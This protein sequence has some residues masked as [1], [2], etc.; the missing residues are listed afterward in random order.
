MKKIL[1]VDDSE[2]NLKILRMILTK[3]GY[4]VVTIKSPE[5]VLDELE[6]GFD[7]IILDINM[8]VKNGYDLCTEIILD[9]RYKHIPVIFNS[10]LSNSEDIVKGFR[11][12]AVDYITKPFKADEVKV[13]VNTHL[14]I[15]DL[16]NEL[17]QTNKLLEQK[18][19]EQVQK[20]S[21]TQMETIFSLARLAQ[22]RD[23]DTG[24]H[25]ERV[26]TYCKLLAEKLQA[27]S[28]YSS[29]IDN[30]F[31]KNIESASI[32]HDI[33]K[34]GVSDLIL[35]KPG[36]LTPEE[37]EHVKEHTVIGFETID[38][39]DKKFGGNKFLEMGKVLVRSHHE[40]FDGKG[41]P[42]KLKGEEIPLSARIMAIAD[43]YDALSTKRVYKDAFPQEKCVEIIKEGRGT[44]FDPYIV[45]AFLQI[46]DEFAKVREA[47]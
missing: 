4:E 29:Q 13:R 5:G 24:K 19:Q 3:E 10:A 1:V 43:V 25:L 23:D 37:F 15:A 17:R 35:L 2:M 42:D 7:M 39:V 47:S 11:A 32:L 38:V 26:Q 12:G 31:V 36:K 21:D 41:Y 14:Q 33:G 44:Q 6:Q 9:D 22:S 30:E 8:P 20:I 18:I 28:P 16:Q 45:D 34:V 46:A 40:R 27:D